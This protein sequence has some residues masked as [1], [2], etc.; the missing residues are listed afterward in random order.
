MEQRRGVSHVET[1][2]PR[3]LARAAGK[4]LIRRQPTTITTGRNFTVAAMLPDELLDGL[5]QQ[6]PCR[7][8][9]IQ[10]LAGL[11]RVW[12]LT[13]AHLAQLTYVVSSAFPAHRRSTRPYCDR[14]VIT[15]QQLPSQ[16]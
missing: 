16:D 2:S 6:F 12:D 11:Y 7:H 3:T 1:R 8:S 14:Q 10:Q 15:Y 5:F 4:R 13:D 9:Q